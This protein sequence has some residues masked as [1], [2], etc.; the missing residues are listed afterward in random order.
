MVAVATELLT[1]VLVVDMGVVGEEVGGSS[2]L[3]M[4]RAM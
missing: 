3:L 4:P 2:L 1:G